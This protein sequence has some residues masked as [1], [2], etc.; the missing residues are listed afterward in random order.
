ML[1]T[2]GLTPFGEEVVKEMNRLGMI[3]DLSHVHTD[4][5]K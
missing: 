1:G 5:M 3:V 4:T 2:V